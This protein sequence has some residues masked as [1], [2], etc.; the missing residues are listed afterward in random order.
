[1]IP[2]EPATRKLPLLGGEVYTA[3]FKHLHL[4]L[5]KNFQ[6]PEFYCKKMHSTSY[7]IFKILQKQLGTIQSSQA[8]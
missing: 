4:E 1:M 2:T 7:L 5:M 6:K 8:G 3:S